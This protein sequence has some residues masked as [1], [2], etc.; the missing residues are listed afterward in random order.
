MN[1]GLGIRGLG[2]HDYDGASALESGVAPRQP[3]PGGGGAMRPTLADDGGS[4]RQHAIAAVAAAGSSLD[5]LTATAALPQA[6]ADGEG[7]G[8]QAGPRQGQLGGGGGSAPDAKRKRAAG[9]SSGCG[10]A[11]Q[12]DG[13]KPRLQR[14]PSGP[15]GLASPAPQQQPIVTGDG[16]G[17]GSG[18]VQAQAQDPA[19][20]QVSHRLSGSLPLRR[21][22]SL[23]V[24]LN[25]MNG[26]GHLSGS[27]LPS[28]STAQLRQPVE[29]TPLA[30]IVAAAV[31][32]LL[33]QNSPQLQLA[34][35]LAGG[36][37]TPQLPAALGG[38][39]ASLGA[40][41]SSG[42]LAG[43]GMNGLLMN[44]TSPAV[45]AGLRPQRQQAQQQRYDR[46]EDE[47]AGGEEE[48]EEEDEETDDDKPFMRPAPGAAQKYG[49]GNRVLTY[50]D[51]AA[52]VCV[53]FQQAGATS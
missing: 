24:V 26:S 3:L 46:Q 50:E 30:P 4:E 25:G 2:P 36:A 18:A 35:L 29:A 22:G 28:G 9:E 45:T 51:L 15:V 40:P 7:M 43:S 11:A 42:G 48:E 49:Q 27:G 5:I 39:F 41:G 20:P 16:S 12:E 31:Q 8:G 37:M 38:P 52:Q 1:Q 44:G 32:Q 14:V 10:G 13:E 19:Q 47:A 34:A 21:N 6:Q 33:A 53:L 17:S 23:P